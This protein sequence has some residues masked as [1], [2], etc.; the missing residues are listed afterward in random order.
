MT[1]L[2]GLLLTPLHIAAAVNALKC[3]Q[4]IVNYDQD[5]IG[6]I[7]DI[8]FLTLLFVHDIIL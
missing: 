1:A 6:Y 4:V 5:S 2:N 8:F 7:L 3:G